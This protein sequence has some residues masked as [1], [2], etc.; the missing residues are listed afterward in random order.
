VIDIAD[1]RLVIIAIDYRIKEWLG[2][3]WNFRGYVR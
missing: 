1:D 2:A 3:P